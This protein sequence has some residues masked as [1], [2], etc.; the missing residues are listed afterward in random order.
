[1]Q[2]NILL[3]IL[4]WRSVHDMRHA[5]VRTEYLNIVSERTCAYCAVPN[6]KEEIARLA[7]QLSEALE[8]RRK[9][10]DEVL[11]LLNIGSRPKV[12]K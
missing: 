4:L 9:F 3:W 2:V 7:S 12:S 1:M 5:Y 10:P 8:F 11:K 6:W